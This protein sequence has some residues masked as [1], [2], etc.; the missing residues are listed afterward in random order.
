MF[1]LKHKLRKP[2]ADDIRRVIQIFCGSVP[3][4]VCRA[5]N[6]VIE[7]APHINSDSNQ[8]RWLTSTCTCR[9]S[10]LAR[11]T[12]LLDKFVAYGRVSTPSICEKD[13]IRPPR[14]VVL[15]LGSIEPLGFDGE[16]EKS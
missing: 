8:T 9:K 16:A 1:E 2:L 10:E 5:A 3:R 11:I 7:I 4:I 15:K 13:Q 6:Q 14:A 12:L